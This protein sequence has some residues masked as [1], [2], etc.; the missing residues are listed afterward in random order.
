MACWTA[1]AKWGEAP[2]LDGQCATLLGLALSEG[3]G[4]SEFG[5]V[6][7]RTCVPS[8]VVLA[9]RHCRSSRGTP[10]LRPVPG[11]L[12]GALRFAPLWQPASTS[13]FC[14]LQTLLKTVAGER[15][16]RTPQIALQL[17]DPSLAC[18]SCH[19]IRAAPH[20]FV[21]DVVTIVHARVPLLGCL[22]HAANRAF[23]RR[24]ERQC[25]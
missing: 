7:G 13:L 5:K 19:R 20:T 6:T 25:F 23:C 21:G 4:F 22:A 2:A 11:T 17:L 10:R 12:H 9:L 15:S 14:S 1:S 3:L 18:D 16:Q 8:I 24:T